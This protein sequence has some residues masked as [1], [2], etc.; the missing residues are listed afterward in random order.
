[1]SIVN[2]TLFSV[3]SLATCYYKILW[4]QEIQS[5]LSHVHV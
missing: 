2:G 3:P 4:E 1:M 5:T